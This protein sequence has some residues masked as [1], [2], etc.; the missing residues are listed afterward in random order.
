MGPVHMAAE[1][2]SPQDGFTEYPPVGGNR[3]RWGD[4]GAAAVDGQSVYLAGQFIEQPP[5]TLADYIATGL[6]CFGSRSSL[7]NWSTRVSRFTP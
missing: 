2:K 5:C 7:A 1:G 6:T 3:P 4:Y